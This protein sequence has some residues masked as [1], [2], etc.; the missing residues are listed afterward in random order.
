MTGISR[1]ASSA[2][3]ISSHNDILPNMCNAGDR[4]SLFPRIGI[5]DVIQHQPRRGGILAQLRRDIILRL[6]TREGEDLPGIMPRL[7][8]AE[9]TDISPRYAPI[10]RNNLHLI[11]NVSYICTIASTFTFVDLCSKFIYVKIF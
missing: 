9:K 7:C 2:R 11:P 5:H 8:V 10:S 1:D 6:R 3:K 4:F